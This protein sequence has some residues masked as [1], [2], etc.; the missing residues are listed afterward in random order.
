MRA[1]Q[2][3]PLED[4]EQ[5]DY[6]SWLRDRGIKHFRVP[7]ETYTTSKAQLGKNTALGVVAGVQD[8]FV[9]ISPSQSKDGEGYL[10]AVEMK[11]IKGSSTSAAQ[12]EWFATING[13]GLLNVQAYICRGAEEAKTVTSHY[14]NDATLILG[15]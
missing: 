10:L 3:V 14:L 7:N 5:R 9:V 15:F 11:R 1:D 13:L 4:V 12:K 6:V 8:L 2:L